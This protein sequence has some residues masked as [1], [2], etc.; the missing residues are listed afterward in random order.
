MSES[1]RPPAAGAPPGDVETAEPSLEAALGVM[2]PFLNAA[3]RNILHA[4]LPEARGGIDPPTPKQLRAEQLADLLPESLWPEH[5]WAARAPLPDWAAGVAAPDAWTPLAEVAPEPVR[6]LWPGLLPAGKLTVLAGDPGTGKSFLALDWA[7]RVS[8]GG[9]FPASGIGEGGMTNEGMSNDEGAGGSSFDI[10]HSSFVL[11]KGALLFCGEDD[12]ADTVR[13]RLDALGADPRRVTLA[14]WVTDKTDRRRDGVKA[15]RRTYDLAA[16]L[17]RLRAKLDADAAAGKPVGLVVVDPLA[18]F[19]PRTNRNHEGAT[20][21]VLD[22]LAALARETGA[23]VV[24]VIHLRK[25]RSGPAVLGPLESIAQAAVAR[26]VLL[27]AEDPAV[28]GGSVLMPAKAN[29]AGR[30]GVIPFRVAGGVVEYSPPR[31]K[32]PGPAKSQRQFAVEWIRNY[33]ADGPRLARDAM[34]DGLAAGICRS[35]LKLARR[36]L[37]LR[38]HR[39]RDPDGVDAR[40][41][42]TGALW[43]WALPGQDP[44]AAVPGHL[45]APGA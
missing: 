33:L 1:S 26:S 24:A 16:D 42:A 12:P 39:F 19:V 6:W 35:T 11:P 10:P 41:R 17:P 7:A 2:E 21:L 27:C 31:T 28:A 15:V 5:V 40:G 22:P 32:G 45:R 30:A 34:R 18:A 9:A 23:A 43:V 37:G 36:D 25:D 38:K 14:G 44:A 4:G 8:R 29:L 3:A 20:R 13:P